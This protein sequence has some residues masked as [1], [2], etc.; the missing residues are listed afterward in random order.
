[1]KRYPDSLSKLAKANGTSI[2][3][4]MQHIRH[5]YACEVAVGKHSK[6]STPVVVLTQRSDTPLPDAAEIGLSDD[7]VVYVTREDNAE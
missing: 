6:L 7:D 5:T 1:M 2:A 3:E 4:V